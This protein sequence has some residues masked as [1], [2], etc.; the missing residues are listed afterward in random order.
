MKLNMTFEAAVH[1]ESGFGFKPV[2]S[3]HAD[4]TSGLGVLHDLVEHWPGTDDRFAVTGECMAF[5]AIY[6]LRWLT[7]DSK[8]DEDDDFGKWCSNDMAEVLH[9]H[10]SQD[11]P[12][13]PAPALNE[14]D[15]FVEQIRES[16]SSFAEET[17]AEYL[18]RFIW[19][20][21]EIPHNTDQQIGRMADWITYGYVKANKRFFHCPCTASLAYL[22]RQMMDYIDNCLVFINETE[23]HLMKVWIDTVHISGKVVICTPWYGSPASDEWEESSSNMPG[24]FRNSNAIAYTKEF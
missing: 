7:G 14:S 9:H 15:L 22:M 12:L 13:P 11:M 18:D 8:R 20:E 19:S 1:E 10:Y 6:L 2:G 5:G 24:C 3:T 4:P 17:R 23:G 21:K 16:L